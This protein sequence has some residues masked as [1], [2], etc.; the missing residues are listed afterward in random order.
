M[1]TRHDA[2]YAGTQQQQQPSFVFDVLMLVHRS[3]EGKERER[4]RERE[5]KKRLRD[6][7]STLLEKRAVG[8]EPIGVPFNL[9]KCIV[10]RRRA[11]EPPLLLATIRKVRADARTNATTLINTY[12]LRRFWNFEFLCLF[13]SAALSYSIF[14]CTI[15]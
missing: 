13:V 7:P 5:S 11:N 3:R 6:V 8:T 9:R 4:K 1:R 10:G 12:N 15:R 2:V 14:T